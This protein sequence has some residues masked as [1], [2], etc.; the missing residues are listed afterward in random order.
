MFELT[1]IDT[2]TKYAWVLPLKS[3]SGIYIT[4]GFKIVL[5]ESSQGGFEDRKP[6]KLW[7]DK[8]S[9]FYKKTNI[10]SLKEYEIEL[11]STNSDLKAVFIERFI[12]RLLQI[13]NKTMFINGDGN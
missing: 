8:G 13:I 10:S 3:K 1:V 4:N 11:Y 7:I 9:E 6:E 2:F 5:G 12:R